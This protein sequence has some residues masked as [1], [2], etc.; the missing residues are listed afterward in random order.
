[1]R[2]LHVEFLPPAPLPRW[3][4]GLLLLWVAAIAVLGVLAWREMQEVDRLKAQI[5]ELTARKEAAQR[6]QQAAAAAAASQ[7]YSEELQAAIALSRFP[8]DKP[9]VALESAE[10]A[11]VLPTSVD[12]DATTGIA[13]VELEFS[14]Y[15]ALM[16]YLGELN[17]GEPT[18]QWMLVSAQ[19]TPPDAGGVAEKGQAVVQWKWEEKK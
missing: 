2:A 6:E 12:I 7:P 14:D 15:D 17:A 13:R 9:L 5:A 16:K 3:A 19:Q 10:V 1:M 4:R 18:P 11:G 8:L